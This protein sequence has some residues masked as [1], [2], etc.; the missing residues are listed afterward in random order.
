M[1]H[2]VQRADFGMPEG[3]K[4]GNPCSRRQRLP[5][6]F[7]KCGDGARLQGV[8]AHLD[9]HQFSPCEGRPRD[10]NPSLPGVKRTKN[11]EDR[12]PRPAFE[13]AA[14]YD[15]RR[16]R[17]KRPTSLNPANAVSIKLDEA[18]S[19]TA[20]TSANTAIQPLGHTDP[21]FAG[22]PPYGT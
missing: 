11:A 16:R 7:F 10:A 15:W 9:D 18:D 2:A 17:Q 5:K 22:P 14:R 4:G 12:R 6:A 13:N 21:G 3:G 19:G 1:D 20:E 8:A